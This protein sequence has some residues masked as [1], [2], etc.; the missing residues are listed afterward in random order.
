MF[1]IDL[2]A[3][4]MFLLIIL[5]KKLTYIQKSAKNPWMCS[6]VCIQSECTH[7]AWEIM[8]WNP[9]SPSRPLC[10]I[11][12]TPRAGLLNFWCH[13]DGFPAFAL[14]RNEILSWLL[15]LHVLLW[16]RYMF[17]RCTRVQSVAVE[18]FILVEICHNL[19]LHS[20]IG[21]VGYFQLFCWYGRCCYQHS[22]ANLLM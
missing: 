2:H 20:A 21:H 8:L 13:W 10:S 4:V 19:F 16:L 11:A 9:R 7:G 14:F 22:Y 3:A 1:F 18:Y 6:S 5:W 17:V 12:N 15:F